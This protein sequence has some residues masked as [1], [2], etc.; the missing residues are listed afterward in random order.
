MLAG[1]LTA[2]TVISMAASTMSND[3]SWSPDR[4]G[5]VICGR[6]V[7]VY[8]VGPLLLRPK[9]A[10]QA[11]GLGR[12]RNGQDEGQGGAGGKNRVQHR[13]FSTSGA[14]ST[15]SCLAQDLGREEP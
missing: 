7:T 4:D 13:H 2:Y 5:V 8:R 1:S 9:E 11:M 15:H 12:V 6:I 10:C 14:R 3:S